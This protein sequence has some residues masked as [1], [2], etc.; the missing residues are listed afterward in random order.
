MIS[1]IYIDIDLQDAT[2]SCSSNLEISSHVTNPPENEKSPAQSSKHVANLGSLQKIDQNTTPVA[3]LYLF[4]CGLG[5][6]IWIYLNHIIDLKNPVSAEV[7]SRGE[8]ATDKVLRRIMQ[9]RVDGTYLVPQEVLEAYRDISGGGR[10][11]VQ[12]M[13]VQASH[14]KEWLCVFHIRFG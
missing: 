1:L 3:W 12:K 5:C 13:W 11:R 14:D 6:A 7:K 10:E 2:A 8:S 9:P 4:T